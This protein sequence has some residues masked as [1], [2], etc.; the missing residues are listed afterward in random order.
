MGLFTLHNYCAS[1]SLKSTSYSR[2]FWLS[3]YILR[4]FYSVLTLY[5]PLNILY[6]DKSP[7]SRNLETILS[8]RPGDSGCNNSSPHRHECWSITGS[9][10]RPVLPREI[11]GEPRVTRGLDLVLEIGLGLLLLPPSWE[12][13]LLLPGDE[14]SSLGIHRV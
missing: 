11:P 9:Q 7:V 12:E 1:Y 10:A 8:T 3:L 6:L 4:F 13:C 2:V 5:F 14:E